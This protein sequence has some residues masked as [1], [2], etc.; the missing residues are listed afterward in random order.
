MID[1]TRTKISTMKFV[2]LAGCI[3]IL[4]GSEKYAGDNKDQAKECISINQVINFIIL[5]FNEFG[6]VDLGHGRK[7]KISV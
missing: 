6:T 2:D 4:K 5:D 1:S 3:F 7:R